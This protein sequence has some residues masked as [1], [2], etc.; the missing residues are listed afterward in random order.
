MSV[1]DIYCSFK[2]LK[3]LVR[4]ER[5]RR[6]KSI[7]LYYFLYFCRSGYAIA[8]STYGLKFKRFLFASFTTRLLRYV[9]RTVLAYVQ[10]APGILVR[11]SR[12]NVF[13]LEWVLL[14]DFPCQAGLDMLQLV[15]FKSV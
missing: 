6:K 13:D 8:N 5:E 2:K 9:L 7:K 3:T 1:V 15:F 4:E 10:N 12:T 11:S 14:A